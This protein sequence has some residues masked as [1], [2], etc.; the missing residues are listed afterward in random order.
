MLSSSSQLNLLFQFIN[1][2]AKYGI[3]TPFEVNISHSQKGYFRKFQLLS[4]R[5]L[6]LN[7][8]LWF[9]YASAHNFFRL[10]PNYSRYS[11]HL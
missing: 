5:N 11:K 1:T 7:V 2:K 8:F 9:F 10:E 4:S 6:F 3:E